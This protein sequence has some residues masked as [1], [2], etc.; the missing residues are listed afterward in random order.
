VCHQ[1]IFNLI[2]LIVFKKSKIIE[3]KQQKNLK[4]IFLHVCIIFNIFNVFSKE[5]K[6]LFS[7][8]TAINMSI[9][10]SFVYFSH[11]VNVDVAFLKNI[12]I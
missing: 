4:N 12:K 7:M 11:R 8:F 3:K 1:P 9:S 6:I 2:I 5:F 10:K